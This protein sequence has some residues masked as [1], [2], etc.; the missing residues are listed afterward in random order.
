MAKLKVSERFIA[1]QGEGRYAGVPSYFVRTFGCSLRCPSFGR[2]H[3]TEPNPDVQNIIKLIPQFEA[4]G[5]KFSDLPLSP[6]GC[7]TYAAV[8]PEF[9][10]FSPMIEVSD[11]VQIIREELPHGNFH[12]EQHLILTGGEPLLPG[13]QKG[14]PELI[15]ELY[16]QDMVQDKKLF[17]T[18]ETNGTQK[19]NQDH[20]GS[21]ALDA[22]LHFSVSP[23]LMAS[24][25]LRS[26]TIQPDVVLDYMRYGLVDFKFVVD[27]EAGVEEVIDVLHNEYKYIWRSPMFG[28]VYLMPEGGLNETYS[29]NAP[30]VADLAIK[31]GFRFSPRL[32]NS[33]SG[34]VWGT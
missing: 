7:D 5:K 18:I 26:E 31:H 28:S 34:N 33:L 32:Q 29:R 22:N 4:E 15:A 9:K 6:T 21:M 19:I 17:V 30:K 20:F 3:S 12:K 2:D 14:Y 16:R 24:G 27:S 8:Y 13:W 10:N 1:L 25:E 23:K 11:L